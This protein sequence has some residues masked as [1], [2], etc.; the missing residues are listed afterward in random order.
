MGAK[1]WTVMDESGDPTTVGALGRWVT[2]RANNEE[3]DHTPASARELAAALIEAA[4]L[5]EGVRR[6]VGQVPD[7]PP[8]PDY[9]IE[10]IERLAECVAVLAIAAQP[11]DHE[12]VPDVRSVVHGNVPMIR[13]AIAKANR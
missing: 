13:R 5:V 12:A 8:V 10:S 1:T 9:V 6:D 11:G 3:M 7:A 4:D 2:T